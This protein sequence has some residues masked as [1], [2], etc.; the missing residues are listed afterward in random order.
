LTK[1]ATDGTRRRNT[2]ITC[3]LT[4]AVLLM[5]FRLPYVANFYIFNTFSL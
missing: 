3:F 4:V 1:S 2:R 5:T